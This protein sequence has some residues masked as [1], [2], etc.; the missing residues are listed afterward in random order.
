MRPIEASPRS[1]R[2][3]TQPSAIIGQCSMARY[4]P[5][6]TNS[7]RV[8]VPATTMLPP[9]QSTVSEPRPIRKPIPGC[10]TPL[11]RT[12]RRLRETYSS[13]AS[14]KRASSCLSCA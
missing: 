12:S 2:F 4:T 9:S 11:M 7:P 6:A 13:L 1:N 5:K 10:R 3:T 8:I 14:A